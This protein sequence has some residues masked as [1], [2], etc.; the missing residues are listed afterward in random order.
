MSR[1]TK[2]KQSREGR[3]WVF[4][5]GEEAQTA[6]HSGAV[7]GTSGNFLFCVDLSWFPSDGMDSRRCSGLS[8]GVQIHGGSDHDPEVPPHG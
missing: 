8:A 4:C 1:S 3:L 5:R 7:C 2:E 6:D